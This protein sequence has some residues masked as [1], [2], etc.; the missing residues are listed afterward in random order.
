MKNLK[1]IRPEQVE[2]IDDLFDV[3]EAFDDFLETQGL[4]MPVLRERQFLD[5]T[6]GEKDFFINLPLFTPKTE[7]FFGRMAPEKKL[8]DIP[9]YADAFR[10]SKPDYA[11]SLH[12]LARAAIPMNISTNPSLSFHELQGKA[13]LPA[14]LRKSIAHFMQK[15]EGR[16][17]MFIL[18]LDEGLSFY[19]WQ[20]VFKDLGGLA[21]FSVGLPLA[22][23]SAG[24]RV[25]RFIEAAS[26]KSTGRD[27][28]KFIMEL[29][30]DLYRHRN[31]YVREELYAIEA[32]IDFTGDLEKY[33]EPL[34]D[35]F[36]R[37]ASLL[38]RQNSFS[39]KGKGPP[40]CRL[41]DSVRLRE[42]PFRV[43]GCPPAQ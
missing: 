16:G 25:C 35:A 7:S 20:T 30:H 13:S 3:I 29:A 40:L 43:C 1:G 33:R 42:R 2:K 15:D 10:E 17:Q 6:P 22:V 21:N 31:E 36:S 28:S 34:G 9:A 38:L 23:T 5:H 12:L 4:F 32:A 26:S 18:L 27:F 37:V 14:H 39:L 19:L 24:S 11:S 8:V 41:S